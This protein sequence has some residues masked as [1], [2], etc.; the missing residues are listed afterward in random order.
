MCTY[1]L[2]IKLSVGSDFEVYNGAEN[3]T[4]WREHPC[5][6][7]FL[8]LYGVCRRNIF[9][10]T[11]NKITKHTPTCIKPIHRLSFYENCRLTTI[12]TSTI[13]QRDVWTKDSNYTRKPG[14][15]ETLALNQCRSVTYDKHHQHYG[16]VPFNKSCPYVASCF[17]FKLG[18]KLHS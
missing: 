2:S 4:V 8:G 5:C 14:F 13:T 6:H 1:V 7:T 18:K 9:I 17:V 3:L 16:T 12:G 11:L 15:A 10:A